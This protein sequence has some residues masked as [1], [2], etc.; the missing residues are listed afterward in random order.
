M[1]R[2]CAGI[3]AATVLVAFVAAAVARADGLPVLGVNVGAT[4]VPSPTKDSRYVTLPAGAATVLARVRA[5]G[6]QVL[7]VAAS[8]RPLYGAGRRV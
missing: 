8:S 6:G 5:N 4:G 7:L 3:A 2:R 1:A